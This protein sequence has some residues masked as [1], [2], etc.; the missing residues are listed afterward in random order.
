VL[1]VA[2]PVALD[3]GRALLKV[4]CGYHE[5]YLLTHKFRGN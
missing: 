2:L 1:P 4:N 3:D 5:A